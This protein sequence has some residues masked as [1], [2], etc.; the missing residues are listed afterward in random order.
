MKLESENFTI[1]EVEELKDQ[2]LKEVQTYKDIEVDLSNVLKIDMTAI[3]L[4]L[5]LK[6]SCEQQN[7]S[8]EIINI[9]TNVFKAF[10]LSG[11]DTALGV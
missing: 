4:L 7:K 2:L 5:S 11:C 1:Y 10:Q 8:L 6:K 9:D 3:Q